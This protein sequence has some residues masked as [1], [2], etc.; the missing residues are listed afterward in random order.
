MQRIA[1]FRAGA[2]TRTHVYDFHWRSQADP[3]KGAFHAI[4]L[5][6]AF[7]SFDVDGWREFIGADDGA[8]ALGRGMRSAWAAFARCGNPSTD[9]LGPWPRY[10]L[11]QRLTMILDGTS[12]VASDPFRQERSMWRPVD[13]GAA[14]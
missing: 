10:D 3:D 8:E 14:Q 12:I 1:D 6:F 2:G 5:P 11:D 7:D 9:E 13:G 4:D